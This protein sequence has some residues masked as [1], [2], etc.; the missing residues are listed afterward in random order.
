MY[1][2][3]RYVDAVRYF[4]VVR[5]GTLG[6]AARQSEVLARLALAEEAAGQK[7]AVTATLQRF[8]SMQERLGGFDATSLEPDLR[9]KFQAL[10]FREI[11]RDR[12]A[13]NPELAY[14]FGLSSVK[15]PPRPTATPAPRVAAVPSPESAEVAP[16]S[17][18]RSRRV[19]RSRPARRPRRRERPPSFPSPGAAIIPTP[20]TA[21][22]AAVPPP[23]PPTATAIVPTATAIVPSATAIVPTATWTPI[24]PTRTW[25]P[26][27]PTPTD[28]PLPPTATHTVDFSADLD[29]VA[30]VDCRRRRRRRSLLRVRS[31][32][33]APRRRRDGVVHPVAHLHRVAHADARPADGNVHVLTLAHVSASRTF[34]PSRTWT[35]PATSTFHPVSNL[36]P[37][38]TSTPVPRRPH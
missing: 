34:T 21:A 20:P 31:R 32:R 9:A 18:A 38:L 27:P 13:Q 30:H 16:Q 4:R 28:T 5:F 35:P 37:S 17:A 8:V 3:G 1:Q 12:I 11:R 7:E 22:A 10:V 26:P 29:P 19:L 36:S 33:A 25:T 6:D 14:A 15:P 24:P 23:A 2:A